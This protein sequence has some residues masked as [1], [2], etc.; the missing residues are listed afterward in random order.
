[1]REVGY[2]TVALDKKK[3]IK[4]M[5]NTDII[6]NV[7]IEYL[8]YILLVVT[9]IYLWIDCFIRRLAT[10]SPFSQDN[11]LEATLYW[12]SVG[13]NIYILLGYNYSIINTPNG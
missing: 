6:L 5:W 2:V 1:M 11:L 10:S 7:L 3:L 12:I 4:N 8:L 13:L 9:H